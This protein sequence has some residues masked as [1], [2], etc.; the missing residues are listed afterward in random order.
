MQQLRL[1]LLCLT[2]ALAGA[3]HAQSAVLPSHIIIHDYPYAMQLQEN[4]ALL[5]KLGGAEFAAQGRHFRG[6]LVGQENS[7]VRLSKI[8]GKWSGIVSLAGEN[9]IIQDL[10]DNMGG[11]L[12]THKIQ[13]AGARTLLAKPVEELDVEATQCGTGTATASSSQKPHSALSAPPAPAAQQAQ[14][15]SMCATTVDGVCMIAEVE[16]VFDQQF[17]QLIG[18]AAQSTAAAIV[19]MA[20]GF[21]VHDLKVSFDA[22]TMQFPETNVFS[23]STDAGALLVDIRDKKRAGQLPFI[24]NNE[25]LLHLVTGRSFA[26][27]TAGIAYT[28]VLCNGDSNGIGTSQLLR[29]HGTDQ[30]ALTAL[31]VAHEIGHNFGANHDGDEK[32]GNNCGGGSIMA[33]RVSAG[34]SQ[35]S[36]CSIAEMERTISAL[37][38][39]QRCFNFPVDIAISANNDNA[40]EVIA[41][42]A[43]TTEYTVQTNATFLALPQLRVAGSV[44]AEQGRFVAVTLN[45]AACEVT[46]SMQ[47][48]SCVLQNPGG[49]ANLKVVARGKESAAAYSHIASV[50]GS[51]DL[52]DTVVDNN[53]LV[54]NFS[55]TPAPPGMVF[56]DD[57]EFAVTPVAR[58]ASAN[59]SSSA[60]GEGGGGGGSFADL[61][62]LM[63]LTALLFQRQ[64]GVFR[65]AKC[66]V[67]NKAFM[68]ALFV[69]PHLG[70]PR[71]CAR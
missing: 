4:V 62:L 60:D 54:A 61:A 58:A 68:Y 35:F 67:T 7:W 6:Q 34:A 46:E 41:G 69:T 15:N 29:R 38:R 25:A 3:G 53:Q 1:L 23:S 17:Q 40:N 16:F 71:Y 42:E 8:A 49:T 48:Y 36:S 43:F 2:L 52:L 11:S 10:A 59:Q 32:R 50:G 13:K 27:G 64:S 65:A 18:D 20:E 47:A 5:A 19:N 28:G 12:Q 37:N 70:L 14:F 56:K 21:Y 51:S 63:L 22:I 33:P 66:G 9:H 30:A 31:V 55:V 45:G 26:G 24:K 57:A 44:P 39:P